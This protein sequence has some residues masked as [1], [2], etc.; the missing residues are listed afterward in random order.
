MAKQINRL[1]LIGV[2]LLV[3]MAGLH[4]S[5]TFYLSGLLAE[6]DARGFLKEIFPIVFAHVSLHLLVLAA[7]G[8]LAAFSP[9][10]RRPVAAIVAGAIA[11][12]AA[13]A[14]ALGAWPPAVLLV[15]AAAS[16][17]LAAYRAGDAPA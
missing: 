10:A 8:L 13:I 6:S 1:C 9:A 4:S 3:G 2:V 5:G 11:L 7:F 12:D 16:F 17:A 15:A 14:L